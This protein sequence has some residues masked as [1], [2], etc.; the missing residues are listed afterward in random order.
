MKSG[1]DNI[2]CNQGRT[3][4]ELGVCQGRMPACSDA[5]HNP[6]IVPGGLP[7]MNLPVARQRP[8]S[9]DTHHLPPGGFWFAPGTIEAPPRP[10]RWGWLE[11]AVAATAAIAATGVLAGVVV[12]LVSGVPHG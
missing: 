7:V 3:C 2:S 10:E 4:A 8:A 5:C 6:A 11:L 1:C 12:A 9:I